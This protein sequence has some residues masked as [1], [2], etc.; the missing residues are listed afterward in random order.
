MNS[1]SGD[2]WMLPGSTYGE[3]NRY[4]ISCSRKAERPVNVGRRGL[5]DP[6]RATLW[7]VGFLMEVSW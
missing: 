1:E 5:K 6:G 7:G 3:E 4:R 2:P